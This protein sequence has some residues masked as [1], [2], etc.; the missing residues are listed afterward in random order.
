ML[1]PQVK[2]SS[3]LRSL[4]ALAESLRGTLHQRDP[5]TNELLVDLKNTDMY[6]KVLNQISSTYRMD[7]NKLLFSQT[8]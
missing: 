4:T 8:K 3:V 7:G 1:S 6:L 5:E 2:L